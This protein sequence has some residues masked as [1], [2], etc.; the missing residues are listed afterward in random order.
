[1]TDIEKKELRGLNIKNI[2]TVILATSTI[3]IT[4]VSWCAKISAQIETIKND[5]VYEKRYNDLR[6]SILE[7]SLESLRITMDNLK[8]QK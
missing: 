6:M 4:T 1:M 5:N 2:I 7:K 3:V 8:M